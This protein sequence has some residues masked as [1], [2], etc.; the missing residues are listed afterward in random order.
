[1]LSIELSR[2]VIDRMCVQAIG[3]EMVGYGRVRGSIGRRDAI[4]NKLFTVA[5]RRIPRNGTPYSPLN[6]E[7]NAI[8]IKIATRRKRTSL[9]SSDSDTIL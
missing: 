3:G 8:Y 2:G 4:G 9:N 1:M 7:T 6:S 5:V